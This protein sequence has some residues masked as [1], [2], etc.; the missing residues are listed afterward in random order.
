MARTVVWGAA[1]TVAR[2]RGVVARA[3]PT[4]PNRAVGRGG[5][6]RRRERAPAPEGPALHPAR[7]RAG[8]RCVV[9]CV[10]RFA[11]YFSVKGTTKGAPSTMK[12]PSEAGKV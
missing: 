10:A 4:I 9:R 5:S 3:R 8:V 12:G 11:A 7:S 2:A 1:W 6:G